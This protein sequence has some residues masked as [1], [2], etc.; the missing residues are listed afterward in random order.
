MYLRHVCRIHSYNN[1]SSGDSDS[2]SL[3]KQ[4]FHRYQQ[5]VSHRR[6]FLPDSGIVLPDVCYTDFM[7][8]NPSANQSG[9]LE[10]TMLNLLYTYTVPQR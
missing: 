9:F 6:C 5:N 7:M 4:I 8:Y 2:S 10:A 1:F 3:S